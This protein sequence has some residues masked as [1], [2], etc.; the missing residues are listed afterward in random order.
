MADKTVMLYGGEGNVTTFQSDIFNHFCMIPDC[1]PINAT[2]SL[3]K[4]VV[5]V[6]DPISLKLIITEGL[7]TTYDNPDITLSSIPEQIRCCFQSKFCDFCGSK[8]L[9][10]TIGVFAVVRIE[11]ASQLVVPA[12]DYCL[13]EEPCEIVSP[14]TDPCSLFKS[15]EFPIKEF[16]PST[17]PTASSGSFDV[18][19]A[20][21]N[22]K[23][24]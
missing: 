18:R 14:Y 3:P 24:R 12:C 5:E 13:P 20:E 21:V 19:S 15:L 8:K 2:T 7:C 23:I 17:S 10:I 22:A 16:Y 6:V 11:R 1:N 4:V 9:Y